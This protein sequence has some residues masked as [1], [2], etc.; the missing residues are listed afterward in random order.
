MLHSI[1]SRRLVARKIIKKGARLKY[2]D[3][4]P[5]LIKNQNLGY[6]GNELYN[7]LN[8]KLKKD[9]KPGHIFSKN[10]FFN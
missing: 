4:K 6:K 7:I 3:I 9:I 10:D 8:K 2:I 1:L 5:A